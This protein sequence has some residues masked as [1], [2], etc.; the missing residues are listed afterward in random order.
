[1]VGTISRLQL[2]FQT[3]NNHLHITTTIPDFN[4]HLKLK[5]ITFPIKNNILVC[6]LA[7]FIC[8]S[9]VRLYIAPHLN[10]SC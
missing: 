9:K 1:M 5:K 8:H 2:P 6:F 4:N 7:L 3:Q 10:V